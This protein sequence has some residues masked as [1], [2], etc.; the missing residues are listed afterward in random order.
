MSADN[1]IC[2]LQSRGENG[3]PE[4]RVAHVQNVEM[5]SYD[6]NPEARD[7]YLIDYFGDKPVYRSQEKAS[8]NAF[9]LYSQEMYV[10]YGIVHVNIGK[11][12]PKMAASSTAPD[13][14]EALALTTQKSG[15]RRRRS[16]LYQQVN[17]RST[18]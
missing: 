16:R 3:R 4:F 2:I 7:E 11:P 14:G 13:Q 6:A 15:K 8:K 10:E 12:F 18:G 1:S 5:A 9:D 17:R